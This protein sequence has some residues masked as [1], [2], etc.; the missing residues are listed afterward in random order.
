MRMAETV[1]TVRPPPLLSSPLF[2]VRES[3]DRE[4]FD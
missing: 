1:G 3:L 2:G 4:H